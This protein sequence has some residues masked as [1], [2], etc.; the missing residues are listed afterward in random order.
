MVFVFWDTEG[1]TS[2]EL[3][4]RKK[5]IDTNANGDTLRRLQEAIRKKGPGHCSEM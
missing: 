4:R 3:M 5:T 2:F 1:V